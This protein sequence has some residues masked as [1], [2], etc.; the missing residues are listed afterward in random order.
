[1]ILSRLTA[2]SPIDGRYASQ[3]DT[4][5]PIASELGLMQARIEVELA[6]IKSLAANP[7][8]R[9]V[10]PLSKQALDVIDSIIYN[11]SEKDGKRI[12]TIETTTNHDVKAIEYFIK[13]KFNQ[14]TELSAISGFI[15]FGCTSE[16]INNLSY[17]LMLTRIRDRI[18]TP[19]MQ[20]LI[21]TLQYLAHDWAS[22]SMV[23]RTHG[24][25]ASPTTVGKE[26][27]NVVA[28]LKRQLNQF[29]NV[30][31]LGKLNGAVGNY[32]AHLAAY[33]D[34][35]WAAHADATV[36]GLGL[37]LN[38]YTTQIEPHDCIAEYFDVLKRFNVIL[39]DL[40]RD[41]WGYISLD[42]FKQKI[43]AAEIGSST[44]PHKINPI[45]F[46]NSEGNLGIANAIFEHF[47]AKLPISRWQRDLSDSTVLRNIGVG[48]AHST[49]A[50]EASLKGLKKL[51]INTSAIQIDL[52]QRWEVLAEPIQTVMRRYG[53]KNSYEQLKELTRGKSISE[54]AL[55]EFIQKL[56]IPDSAKDELIKMTPGAYTGLAENQARSI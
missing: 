9:E 14:N 15:H 49:I 37:A 34:V 18:L 8:I 22:I 40:N 47:G 11:F 35:D 27:A 54:K 5:R 21:N 16:D 46:E 32:N 41:L 48:V 26:F 43:N 52:A 33:P 36:T 13:E 29:E 10:P 31:I 45:D 1:M 42:Y 28:R 44:M 24:Q 53:I 3:V 19:K 39:I 12:K 2:L 23:A 51:E 38:P 4:L 17:S 55:R 25:I 30:T 20:A 50:Y 56:D 7:K 6:W